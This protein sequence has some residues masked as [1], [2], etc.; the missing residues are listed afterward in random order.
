[1]SLMARLIA[2]KFAA[3]APKVEEPPARPS[4]PAGILPDGELEDDWQDA[5][6]PRPP[7][8]P[9]KLDGPL[10]A[11][12]SCKEINPETG[13]QC[14]LLAG[15]LAFKLPHRHG[16]TEFVRA[17]APGQTQFSRRDALDAHASTRHGSNITNP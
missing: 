2:A 5:P 4:P 15:H 6:P 16:R 3:K 12:G 1:M 14:A 17:A 11:V 8:L 9:V 13:R 7:A 10:I